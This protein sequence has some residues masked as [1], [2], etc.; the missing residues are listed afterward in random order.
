M[1]DIDLSQV[2]PE[3][4]ARWL[5]ATGNYRVLRKIAMP[6]GFGGAVNH[7]VRVL[8]L[9][10]ETTGLELASAELIEVGALL[11]EVDRDTGELGQIVGSYGGLEEPRNAIPE[12]STAIHG[13]TDEMVKGQRFDDN[14]L[15]AL[16]SKADLCLAHNAGFDKPFL[17][18]RF[19]FFAQTVWACTF[20]ELPWAQEGYSG[21]KLEYLLSDCGYFHAA[22]R[23]VEDCN[24]LAHVLA[25]PLKVSHRMP[26]QVLFESASESIYQIAALKAPF[27]KKD[28]LKARGFRWNPEDRVWEYE[29]VGFSE[30]K[31]IIE[32]L[33]TQ[34][35][36]TTNK[37]MLGFRIQSGTDR[38]S[39]QEVKQQFKEV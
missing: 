39:G 16:V 21:R 37:I 11:V 12:E 1:N 4:V 33:R 20:K 17:L 31:E 15:Q 9:D 23:A 28:F 7:P 30:G 10:T 24:A 22:H 34:V 36:S 19:E 2:N 8:V 25:Q 18:R 6:T 26:M 14:A 32:W 29:A 3:T 5:E 35:Y 38:Y 13:I 27:E